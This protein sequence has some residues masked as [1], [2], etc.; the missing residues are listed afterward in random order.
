MAVFMLEKHAVRHDQFRPF[1]HTQNTR[2]N[3]QDQHRHLNLSHNWTAAGLFTATRSLCLSGNYLT[4]SYTSTRYRDNSRY[5]LRKLASVSYDETSRDTR[6]RAASSFRFQLLP[7]E[8][9]NMI[10]ELVVANSIRTVGLSYLPEA[11]QQR[12]KDRKYRQVLVEEHPGRP[13]LCP[14]T[15]LMPDT[16]N[17]S[18]LRTCKLVWSEAAPM[19][20]GKRFRLDNIEILADFLS[21][22]R[23]ELLACLIEVELLDGI[24]WHNLNRL[25]DVMQYLMQASA[26]QKLEIYFPEAYFAGGPRTSRTFDRIRGNQAVFSRNVD[27]FNKGLARAFAYCLH[28]KHFG[29]WMARIY[30]RGGIRRLSRTFVVSIWQIGCLWSYALGNRFEYWTLWIRRFWDRGVYP[31]FNQLRRTEF[32]EALFVELDRLLSRRQIREQSVEMD[33]IEQRRTIRS[34]LAVDYDTE[35]PDNQVRIP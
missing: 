18:L 17:V 16:H 29:A 15:A 13:S 9:R 35:P 23:P 33:E 8:I 31:Y 1:S 2:A 22:L 32:R 34:W 4:M 24:K 3:H 14:S 6:R 7:R 19:L 5:A 30:R 25:Q 26:L 27:H 21:R 20:Y 11:A 12:S 10:Y 28:K